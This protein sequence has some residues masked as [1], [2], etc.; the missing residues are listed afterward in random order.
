M[1]FLSD[2]QVEELLALAAIHRACG[3]C[4]HHTAQDYCRTCDEFYWIHAPGCRMYEAKHH[5]HR[6][7]IV[8]FT[9]DRGRWT[10]WIAPGVRTKVPERPLF[11]GSAGISSPELSCIFF[12]NGVTAVFR[13]GQ[14]Q[15]LL[16]QS[17]LE[18]F[19]EFLES[20]GQDPILYRLTMP[21]GKEAR[22][23]RTADG[24]SWKF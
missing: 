15:P 20:K 4:G 23:I 10:G 8:P 2:T 3:E 24:W 9:E 21:D 14:Q 22:F 19:A 16:Q 1:P 6:L 12:A 7:T 18:L 5:G 13:D 17:W 11:C